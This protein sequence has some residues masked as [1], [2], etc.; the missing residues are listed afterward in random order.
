MNELQKQT[1]RMLADGKGFSEIARE[2][3]CSRQYVHQM[4]HKA[5]SLRS[6]ATN[7][8]PVLAKHINENYRSAREFAM[9]AGVTYQIVQDMLKRGRVPSWEVIRKL[10]HCAGLTAEELMQR[11]DEAADSE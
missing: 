5:I 6:V 1:L 11:G 7:N 4:A 2:F 10:A 8:Y 9:R 3:G